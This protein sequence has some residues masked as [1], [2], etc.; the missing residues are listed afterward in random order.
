LEVGNNYYEDN[1]VK[2]ISVEEI[3][4]LKTQDIPF[5]DNWIGFEYNE[6]L[7]KYSNYAV[8]FTI[9]SA[10]VTSYDEDYYW[11]NLMILSKIL[12]TQSAIC[13]WSKTFSKRARP[14]LYDKNEEFS[15]SYSRHS[16]YSSHASTA[17]AS[18]VY[19][20]YYYLDNYGANIPVAVLLFGGATATASLR[21]ASA[22]HFPSDV[23]AGAIMGSFTSY[24]ICKIH[25][26]KRIKYNFG[27]SSFS[28]GVE[29]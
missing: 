4:K 27:F 11:D 13:K 22:Q 25:T 17:F 21:V 1:N 3:N 10:L 5:F 14:F 19:A 18:A 15:E 29:F 16:F 7:K 24:L 8:Y 26:A 20:Y 6:K 9:G 23:L 28:I 2:Q 12:M